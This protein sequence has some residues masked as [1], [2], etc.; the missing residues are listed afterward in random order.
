MTHRFTQYHRLG[1][2]VPAE[3]ASDR[4]CRAIRG[5]RSKGARVVQLYNILLYEGVQ[6]NGG[7]GSKSSDDLRAGCGCFSFYCVEI[8]A[9][10][11]I[12]LA[13]CG[14]TCRVLRRELIDR[15]RHCSDI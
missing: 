6:G 10:I 3:W 9:I 12:C 7:D 14:D 8:G 15:V 13:L 1:R 5:V 4:Q 11:L 2:C